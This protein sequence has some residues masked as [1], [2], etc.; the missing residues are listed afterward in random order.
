MNIK[1]SLLCLG[2]AWS[3]TLT[4]PAAASAELQPLISFAAAPMQVAFPVQNSV[5]TFF[6]AWKDKKKHI[7]IH[8]L[9]PGKQGFDTSFIGLIENKGSPPVIESVFLYNVDSDPDH[10]LFV[11]VR[12]DAH[13]SA[14]KNSQASYKTYVF[15]QEPASDGKGLLRLVDVEE[16]IGAGKDVPKDADSLRSLLKKLGY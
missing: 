2:S 1:K 6:N 7:E 16:K 3:L 9:K 12:W 8:V 10:E 4:L 11:L 15:D 14:K 13:D 5:L